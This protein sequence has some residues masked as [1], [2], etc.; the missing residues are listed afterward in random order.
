MLFRNLFFIIGFFLLAITNSD[1]TTIAEECSKR[2]MS[3]YD[4]GSSDS[5]R[6]RL[7]NEALGRCFKE[8]ESERGKGGSSSSSSSGG[9][10]GIIVLLL[11]AAGFVAYKVIASRDQPLTPSQITNLRDVVR[12]VYKAEA[13]DSQSMR[14]RKETL[15]A[16]AEHMFSLALKGELPITQNST[17][18]GVDDARRS[19]EALRESESQVRA[20]VQTALDASIKSRD[21]INAA[22]AMPIED[23][24]IADDP[25]ELADHLKAIEIYKKALVDSERRIENYRLEL[26]RVAPGSSE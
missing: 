10:V 8:M 4:K 20:S 16:D 22:L 1:A 5:E 21:S 14:E 24:G 19:I 13:R 11:F 25:E 23:W 26:A 12:A 18:G 7:G 2:A 6:E 9:G 15:L 3:G 17:R